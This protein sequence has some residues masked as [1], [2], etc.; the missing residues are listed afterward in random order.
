MRK[1]LSLFLVLIAVMVLA[2]VPVFADT[3]TDQLAEISGSASGLAAYSAIV[4]GILGA[5]VFA[6]QVIVGVTKEVPPIKSIPTKLWAI[7]VSVVVCQ[8]AL[9]IYAAVAGISVLWYYIVL[10]AF[11]GFVVAYISINGWDSL[12]ELYLRYAKL[13]E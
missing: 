4:I 2:C 11:A 3:I 10:A 13:K 7:I 8:F 6:V 9:F 1:I 5:M 12:K